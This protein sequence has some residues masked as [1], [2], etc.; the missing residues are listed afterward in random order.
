MAYLRDNGICELLE[1]IGFELAYV[2]AWEYRIDRKTECC[3][4]DSTSALPLYMYLDITTI[5]FIKGGF[6]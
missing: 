6:G 4:G 3:F 1:A 5:R 2:H